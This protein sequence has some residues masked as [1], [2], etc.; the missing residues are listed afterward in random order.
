MDRA[1]WRGPLWGRK[2]WTRLSTHAR[3]E[4]VFKAHSPAYPGG[5]FH[6]TQRLLACPTWNLGSELVTVQSTAV[7]S[8]QLGRAVASGGRD[9]QEPVG[10]LT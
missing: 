6:V 5:L 4:P 1:A 9:G 3:T 2:G 10:V 7:L 8:Q